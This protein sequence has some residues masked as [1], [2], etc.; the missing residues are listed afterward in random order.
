MFKFLKRRQSYQRP[1]KIGEDHMYKD[2]LDL[3]NHQRLPVLFCSFYYNTKSAPS[4]CTPPTLLDMKFYGQQ[5]IMLGQF[6]H[7]YCCRL[8][9][10]CT[11]C[12]LPML[13]HVRR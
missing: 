11:L 5:D 1:Q 12:D 6:L 10:I 13:D 7:R 8:S 4:F 2:A 9:S 3:E